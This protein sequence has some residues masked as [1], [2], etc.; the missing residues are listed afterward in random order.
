M[1]SSAMLVQSMAY[2]KDTFFFLRPLPRKT[3]FLPTLPEAAAAEEVTDFLGLAAA[4]L[5]TT[6]AVFS[7]AGLSV[8]TGSAFFTGAAADLATGFESFLGA[9]F[10]GA[11]VLTSFLTGAA[12][13]PSFLTGAGLLAAALTSFATSGTFFAALAAAAGLV[14]SA[15]GFST[16]PLVAAGAAFAGSAFLAAAGLSPFWVLA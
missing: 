13:F 16:L 2:R 14:A 8:L 15:F 6:L 10:A 4:G 7:T 5:T 3:A 12:V 1:L 9:S 11:A